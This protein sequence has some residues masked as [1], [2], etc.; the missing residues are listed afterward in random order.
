MPRSAPMMCGLGGSQQRA[1]HNPDDV[2]ALQAVRDAV[3]LE[4]TELAQTEIEP[5]LNNSA[6]VGLGLTVTD[7]D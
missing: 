4:P 1:R 3:S 6:S 2:V 7:E 5:A